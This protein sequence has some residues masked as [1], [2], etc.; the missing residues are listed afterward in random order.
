MT[1]IEVV[2]PDGSIEPIVTRERQALLE[3][4]RVTWEITSH[5]KNIQGVRIVFDDPTLEFFPNEN[6]SHQ[7]ERQLQ[8]YDDSPEKKIHRREIYGK[9][10]KR[11]DLTNG[12]CKEYDYTLI[13][14]DDKG[15]QVGGVDPKIVIAKP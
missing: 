15:N 7:I 10:P 9:A 13:A 5:N 3:G 4:Q 1:D 8:E 2:Y 12:T 6:S 14:L 11:D